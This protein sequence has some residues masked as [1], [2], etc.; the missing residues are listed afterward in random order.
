MWARRILRAFSCGGM[1]KGSKY[2]NVSLMNKTILHIKKYLKV[3]HPGPDMPDHVHFHMLRKT[4]AMNLYQEGCPLPYI[5][6]LLEHESISTT[7]GSMRL[8]P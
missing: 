4:R 8:L 5:Q 2:R 3:F 6:Q 7:S 1:G